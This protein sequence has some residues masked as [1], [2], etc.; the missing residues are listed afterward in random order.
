MKVTP[1]TR[2]ITFGDSW[3]QGHGVELDIHYKEVISPNEFTNKLRNSSNEPTERELEII[4]EFSNALQNKLDL[5]PVVEIDNQNS[6]HFYAPI[7]MKPNCLV[8]H[9][10]INETVNIKTDSI[11]KSLYPNDKAIGYAEG[12]LRGIWSITFK[13]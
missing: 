3:T 4:N 1:N 13:N 7:I 11:I 9:G 8:C 10:T 5:K 12:D 2:L 6:K